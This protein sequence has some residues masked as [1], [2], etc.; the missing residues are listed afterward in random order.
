MNRSWFRNP[1]SS[2]ATDAR[3]GHGEADGLD[4]YGD[5]QD[6][7]HEAVA[8]VGSKSG[9]RRRRRQKSDRTG[10]ECK[11]LRSPGDGQPRVGC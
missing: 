4:V 9:R 6:V 5:G 3:S 11:A 8:L 1:F 2:S 7:D 10:S